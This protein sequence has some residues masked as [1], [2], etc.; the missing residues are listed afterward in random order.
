MVELES[1]R[2]IHFSGTIAAYWETSNHNPVAVLTQCSQME[3]LAYLGDEQFRERVVS[4]LNDFEEYMHR[5]PSFANIGSNISKAHPVAYF[6]AE[7]GIHECLPFYSGGLGVLAGDHVKS[8]SDLG[9][10]FVGIGLFYRQGYFQQRIDSTGGQQENYPTTIRNRSGGIDKRP[11]RKA[12]DLYRHD[13][14]KHGSFSGMESG[15]GQMQYLS[16]GY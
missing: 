14:H 5:S 1:T 4:V 10:P 2:T 12:V 7:F 15:C 13:R 16:P 8:A 6:C 3:L 11:I 9:L